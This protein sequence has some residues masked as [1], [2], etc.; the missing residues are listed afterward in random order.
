MIITTK[1]R[2]QPRKLTGKKEGCTPEER[3]SPAGRKK[4]SEVEKKPDNSSSLLFLSENT[5]R[6]T[7]RQIRWLGRR[8]KEAVAGRKS[9][10]EWRTAVA[11][12]QKQLP[13]QSLVC[14]TRTRA[15]EGGRCSGSP[16]VLLVGEEEVRR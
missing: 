3:R 11:G 1:D 7:G 15:E 16:E 14:L 9:P 13:S 10:E 5:P 8:K 12:F 2:S 6:R 4:S